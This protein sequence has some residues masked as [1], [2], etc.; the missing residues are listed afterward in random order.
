MRGWLK[1]CH[2]GQYLDS[3]AKLDSRIFLSGAFLDTF[4]NYSGGVIICGKVHFRILNKKKNFFLKNIKFE[5]WSFDGANW[6][7][8]P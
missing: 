5:I 6:V 2:V 1:N 4:R 3:G 7:I 8:W